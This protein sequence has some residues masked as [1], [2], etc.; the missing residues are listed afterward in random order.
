MKKTKTKTGSALEGYTMPKSE[1]YEQLR[2]NGYTVKF[3]KYGV[4]IYR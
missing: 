1:Y 4:D 3:T 2:A